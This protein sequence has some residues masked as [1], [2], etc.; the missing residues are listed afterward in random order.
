MIKREKVRQLK[1][2]M[3]MQ[4]NYAGIKCVIASNI[5]YQMM[6]EAY[7]NVIFQSRIKDSLGSYNIY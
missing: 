4:F 7:V 3:C 6:S 1:Y 5:S 2:T